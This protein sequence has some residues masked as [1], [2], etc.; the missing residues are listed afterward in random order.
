MAIFYFLQI[1][2][3]LRLIQLYFFVRIY[4]F[5]FKATLESLCHHIFGTNYDMRWVNANFPFTHPSFELEVYYEDRW[6][7]VLGCGIMEQDLLK[8]AG[9][10]DKVGWAFGLGLERLA[11]VSYLHFSKYFCE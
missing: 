10:V 1:L 5:T 4:Y 3:F 9:I 8:M 7:E 6:I 2:I 11:M